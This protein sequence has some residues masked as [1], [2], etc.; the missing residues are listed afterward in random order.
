[1]KTF[2]KTYHLHVIGGAFALFA[3]ALYASFFINAKHAGQETEANLQPNVV[4]SEFITRADSIG[5]EPILK[6]K[7]VKQVEMKL[8]DTESCSSFR[9]KCEYFKIAI[10]VNTDNGTTRHGMLE[11]YDD[12]VIKKM[13]RNASDV[14]RWDVYTDD[15][16]YS[17]AIK[18]AEGIALRHLIQGLHLTMKE[19][20][21]E[22]AKLRKAEWAKEAEKYAVKP[23]ALAS[24]AN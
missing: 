21:E 11:S 16:V 17:M 20:P 9:A 3:V 8:V 22:L 19:T 12:V 2:W 7:G 14:T 4:L 24:P 1:M 18:E 10:S 23:A 5:Q 15:K 13:V 6:V